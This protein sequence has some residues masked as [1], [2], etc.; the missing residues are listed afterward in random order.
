LPADP[1]LLY[2]HACVTPE[3]KEALLLIY[4]NAIFERGLDILAGEVNLLEDDYDWENAVLFHWEI[5]ENKFEMLDRDL[6]LPDDLCCLY[7]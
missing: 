7:R 6:G 2:R 5:K 4:R 3:E 1:C